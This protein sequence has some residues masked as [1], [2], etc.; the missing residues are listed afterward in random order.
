[1][2]L[3]SLR[4]VDYQDRELLHIAT[5]E[6]DTEG[7]VSTEDLAKVIRIS[8]PE[9]NGNVPKKQRQ[10]HAH[11]CI[12]S[13]FAYMARIG[14]VERNEAK[15]MWRVTEIGH[16]LMNGRLSPG[17]SNSLDRL[18]P[19]DRLLVMREMARA[20]TQSSPIVGT[21]LRRQWQHGT[22]RRA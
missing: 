13:R 9:G 16:D 3:H 18:S 15:T 4:N 2:T 17:L 22:G 19:G 11:R 8:H 7:W 12:G 21:A 6:G 10:Y 20:F 1:M 14:W 5:E